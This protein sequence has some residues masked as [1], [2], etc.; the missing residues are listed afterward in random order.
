[1]KTRKFLLGSFFIG[2]TLAVIRLL[3]ATASAKPI[4][5]STSHK[6]IDVYIKEQMHQLVSASC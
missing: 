1:M 3:F 2:D 4:T 5:D 6:V